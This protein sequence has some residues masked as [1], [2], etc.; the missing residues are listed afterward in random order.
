MAPEVAA[1]LI[2]AIPPI[3]G[4]LGLATI[5]FYF[6]SQIRNAL[7]HVS[8]LEVFGLKLTVQDIEQWS[9]SRTTAGSAPQTS[10]AEL[11]AAYERASRTGAVFQGSRFLWTDDH[12]ENNLWERRAFRS[13]GAQIDVVVSNSEAAE[14]L[15]RNEYEIVI[16]DL[17]RD[18]RSDDPLQ[19][20]SLL[21]SSQFAPPYA[22]AVIFYTANSKASHPE[23]S[24]GITVRPDE[25]LHLVTDALHRRRG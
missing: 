2:S 15:R 23:G 24:F 10:F 1:A 9:R 22:P 20:L 18:D 8:S 19:L 25:L 5:I 12:P 14:M 21:R 4:I 17:S 16:S 13:L 3:L 7:R 6:R 11:Q